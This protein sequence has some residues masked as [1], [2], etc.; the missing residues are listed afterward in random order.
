MAD[1]QFQIGDRVRLRTTLA[2]EDG[3]VIF[4]EG[5]AGRVIGGSLCPFVQFDKH[6]NAS[7][8]SIHGDARWW[9]VDAE[10]LELI[11]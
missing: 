1:Q 10:H 5:A 9:Y 4:P 3:E 11:P 2:H 8:E 7:A 6:K